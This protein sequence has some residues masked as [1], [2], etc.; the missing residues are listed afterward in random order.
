M[1]PDYNTGGLKYAE[2]IAKDYPEA[3][4]LYSRPDNPLWQNPPKGTGLD[5]ADW[6]EVLKGED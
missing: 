4:W 3:H 6:L 1:C 5:I 2:A